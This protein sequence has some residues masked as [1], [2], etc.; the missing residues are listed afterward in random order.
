MSDRETLVE[1]M[2]PA[3]VSEDEALNYT[4]NIRKQVVK[5]ACKNGIPDDQDR[6]GQLLGVLKDMDAQS[7]ARKRIKVDE[8][9]TDNM[10]AN[11]SIVA[12]ALKSIGHDM[13][14]SVGL[15][16]SGPPTLS[17]NVS[18]P[19]LAPGETDI[20]TPQPSFDSVMNSSSATTK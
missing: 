10:Q 19:E 6:L 1:D 15:T 17:G 16:R 5:A 3:F 7:V 11:A 13:A 20:G 4:Q 8:K 14:A 2:Q 12:E 18:D 9:A